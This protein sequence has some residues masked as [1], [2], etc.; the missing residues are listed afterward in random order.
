MTS[1]VFK[2]LVIV[3]FFKFILLSTIIIF[4]QEPDSIYLAVRQQL[5]SLDIGV[6]V[7][8]VGMGQSGPEYFH[9]L[10]ASCE[11]RV[12][13]IL[14]CN[15]TSVTKMTAIVLP[16]MIERKRGGVIIN[17]ASATGRMTSP[18]ITIYSATKAYVDF[19]SR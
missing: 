4:Y 6:L 8:N 5:A 15:I 16:G 9:N 12:N 1:L 19:F 18:L 2:T 3:K 7:N 11:D 10:A 14:N 13:D 17:N